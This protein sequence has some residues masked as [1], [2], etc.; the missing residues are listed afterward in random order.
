MSNEQTLWAATEAADHGWESNP[1]RVIA[2]DEADKLTINKPWIHSK[3]SMIS[4][5]NDN[6]LQIAKNGFLYETNI[7]TGKRYKVYKEC[8]WCKDAKNS[9]WIPVYLF[10][11]EMHALAFLSKEKEKFASYGSYIAAPSTELAIEEPYRVLGVHR[12]ATRRQIKQ[13]FRERAKRLHAILL[14]VV[15]G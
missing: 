9:T 5:K 2:A 7:G 15:G 10:P 4:N 13:A 3:K 14:G 12:S 1:I 8:F 6:I 11:Y